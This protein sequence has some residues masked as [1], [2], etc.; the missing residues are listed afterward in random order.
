[1]KRCLLILLTVIC[2]AS[3]IFALP[4]REMRAAWV[5]TVWALDWPATST[6]AWVTDPAQQQQLLVQL[7]DSMQQMNMNCIALQGR[8]MSDAWYESKYEPWSQWLTGTRGKTPTYDPMAFAIKEA[9]KRGMELHVWINPYRYSS[10]ETQYSTNKANADDYA[11]THP[12]WLMSYNGACI[13]NP[14]LP[15]VKTRI[16]SVVADLL[17]KYDVDGILF[18]DYFYLSGTP[19][20]MDAELYKANNPEGLSQAD[21]RREQVNEMVKRVQEYGVPV[22]PFSDWQYNS[23][24]SDP[25]AWMSRR[26]IDYISPQMYWHVGS[27]TCDFAKLSEWWSM[28]A[29]K[30]GRHFYASHSVEDSKAVETVKEVEKLRAD[31]RIDASGSVLYSIRKGIYSNA[32]YTQHMR[33]NVWQTVALP[34]QKWWRRQSQQLFVSDIK[35]SYI[36][37][38]TAPAANSNV[39]YAVYYLPKDSVGKHGQFYSPK[40]LLGLTYETSYKVPLKQNYVY[41][42]SVV[43]RYGNEYAPMVKDMA[44]AVLDKPV[45]TYPADGATPMLPTYLRWEAVGGADSYFIEIARDKEFSDIISFVERGEPRFYTGDISLLETGETYW[46]RVTARGANAE[47]VTSEARNFVGSYFS[48]VAPVDGEKDVAL[49]PEFRCDSLVVSGAKYTFEVS[50]RN[51]FSSMYLVWKGMSEV[52]RVQMPDS[53]LKPAT[54]YYVRATVVAGEMYSVSNARSFRTMPLPVPEPVVLTPHNGDTIAGTE[55][56]V[57]WKEQNASAFRVE[58]STGSSFAPRVTKAV[59]TDMY[60]YSVTIQN[61]QPGDYYLRVRA[62]ADSDYKYSDVL[63]ITVVQPTDVSEISGENLKVKKLLIGGHLY[64]QMPDGRRYDILG[65]ER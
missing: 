24:Y 16:C 57:E 65:R 15:E 64:L 44:K 42:V 26:T 63:E 39:R 56:Y 58:L 7:L 25:L 22:G 40:Y 5:A 3:S 20:S 55:I 29:E 47:D 41:A 50:S 18:D 17:E 60:V 28:I 35:Y 32:G 1:M 12:E 2:V 51:D 46:W 36:L 37:S 19:N 38:W 33:Q 9:H 48:M 59:N 62:T 6:G 43:D 8:T 27:S 54:T 14:G 4:K 23:I 10:S 13:L 52:P 30:Y 53:V 61:V 49:S 31:D 21:W 45:L 11:N 34:P